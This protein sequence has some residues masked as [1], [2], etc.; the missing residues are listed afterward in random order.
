MSQLQEVHVLVNELNN[1]V[2]FLFR[3][4]FTKMMGIR[5]LF[6]ND[7]EAFMQSTGAKLNYSN[8]RL[9]D[10]LYIKPYGL[11]YQKGLRKFDVHVGHYKEVPVLFANSEDSDFPFDIFSAIFYMLTRYEE[12]LQYSPD[13]HGRFQPYESI[14]Y[15][16]NFLEEPIVDE[17]VEIFKRFL[18]EKFPHFNY[19]KHRYHYIP[20]VD[21]DS[22]YSYRN[23]G[24]V[25]LPFYLIRDL[26]RGQ[27]KTFFH[28]LSSALYLKA[29]PFNNFSYLQ[30]TFTEKHKSPVFFF[31][32]GRRG[33]YDKNISLNNAGMRKVL[34]DTLKYAEVGLHPSY[35]SRSK[36]P[37]MEE[38]KKGLEKAIE[39]PIK[40]SRQHYIRFIFPLTFQNLVKIGISEDYSMG[41]ATTC[42]FR[43]GTCTPFNFYDITRDKETEM[44]LIPFQAMDATFINY[45]HKSPEDA[46]QKMQEIREK[47]KKYN[48]VFCLI[49]HNETFAPTKEGLAWRSV[50]ERMLDD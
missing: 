29:D 38:E 42:G 35:G 28:R 6:T 9:G 17:W 30:K 33:K 37:L 26:S 36:L 41:Y 44:R 11:L 20:T 5:P 31:L 16:Y 32:S 25:F 7:K 40:K 50:F 45:L 19:A 23:K 46:F 47:V 13:R 1:R 21:I 8:A 43:A 2:H 10:E 39:L 27:V 4:V 48:G 3:H 14:A 12:Y 22:A 15:Q 18:K 49:W 34:K 24:L